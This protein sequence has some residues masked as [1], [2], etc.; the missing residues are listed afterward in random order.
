M[1]AQIFAKTVTEMG[2]LIISP[3][4]GALD[5]ILTTIIKRVCPKSEG[6]L[7]SPSWTVKVNEN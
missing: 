2:L 5:V 4:V 6:M 1:E 7:Q 3:A